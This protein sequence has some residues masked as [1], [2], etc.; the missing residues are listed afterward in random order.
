MIAT[1]LSKYVND[2]RIVLAIATVVYLGILLYAFKTGY[3]INKYIIIVMVIDFCAYLFSIYSNKQPKL[4]KK[5]GQKPK[6]P[7]KNDKHDEDD[8]NEDKNETKNDDD[9]PLYEPFDN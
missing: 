4:S 1:L 8:K 5:I 9:I 6:N 3:D 7:N 2:M